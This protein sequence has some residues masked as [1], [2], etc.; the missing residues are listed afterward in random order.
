M[1]KI[2]WKRKWIKYILTGLLMYTVNQVLIGS[3]ILHSLVWWDQLYYVCLALLLILLV[4]R[5][6]KRLSKQIL[7][8]KQPS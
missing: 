3:G 2:N 4:G 8:V 6:D 5:I 1:V 7:A